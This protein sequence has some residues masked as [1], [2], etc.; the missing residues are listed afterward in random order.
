MLEQPSQEETWVEV[1]AGA[2]APPPVRGFTWQWGAL[3]VGLA[4]L[5]AALV[6]PGQAD[7]EVALPPIEVSF[8]DTPI[9]TEAAL[10]S[11]QFVN[12]LLARTQ[13]DRDL[14][15]LVFS[16]LTRL[17][18]YGQPVPDLAE[19]WQ[20][21]A[22]G[23][24]YVFSLRQDVTW[25]DGRPFT[26]ADVDFTMRLLRAPDFPGPPELGAFWRTVETY[27]DD[28]YTV[29]FVLTQPLTAFPEHAGIGILPEHWL[30]AVEAGALP[31]DAFNLDPIGTGP[32]DWL[33]V[34]EA[35]GVASVQLAPYA[36]FYDEARIPNLEG[37]H[38]TYYDDPADAFRALGEEAQ[39]LG[40]LS[41]GQ[42]EAAAASPALNIY[43][44]RLPVYAGVLFNQRPDSAAP[45]FTEE[46][47]RLALIQ[48]VDR[49]QVVSTHMG[50]QAALT[51]ALVL[52]G[53][54]AF[55]PLAA[56][57][58]YDPAAA[59][60][61]LEQAGWVRQG[62]TRI[63]DGQRLS[64]ELLVV[65]EAAHQ[66]LGQAL[67]EAWGEIGA[68]VQVEALPPAELRVRLAEAEFEAALVEFAPGGLADPDP[69][70]LWH[71]SQIEAG[72]NFSGFSDPDL[73]EMIETARRDPNGVR[74]AELYRAFQ[75]GFAARGAA[76]LLYNP[77]YH[78]AVSCQVSGVQLHLLRGPEDRFRT[79]AD[80]QMLSPAALTEG[81]PPG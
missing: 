43:S 1:E 37:V 62:G 45:F 77:V 15:A 65:D 49:G 76:L 21:S 46:A 41:P 25:H 2:P 18:E 44:A 50:R 8:P 47:V 33:T 12:P 34:E 54:W 39:A 51:N 59:Q 42:L 69:Y 74:R 9:Y 5:I 56:L 30:P 3:G 40:G 60:A 38:F 75:Q 19:S 7:R 53:T 27:A 4:L 28:D 72:Q 36:G 70:P 31:A 52:A 61:L 13:T 68:D 6:L 24:T 55:D 71:S 64:F 66:G 35:S 63:R 17:D 80:W 79:M 23:L 58:A 48:A 26:A 78:Y 11:P 57:P 10:G 73:D 20:V 29:R 32:L 22:D 14:T 16:G 67:A 81:C